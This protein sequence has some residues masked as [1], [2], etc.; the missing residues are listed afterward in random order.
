MHAEIKRGLALSLLFQKGQ[1]IFGDYIRQIS[2][3]IRQPAVPDH[4]GVMITAAPG[5]MDEP[6]RQTLLGFE[7]VAKMPFTGN[8]AMITVL[9][10]DIGV[11]HLAGQVFD[12][13]FSHISPGDPVVHAVLGRDPPG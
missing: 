13:P 8:S 7:A 2:R 4:R 6:V 10:K 1:P 3:L 5:L 11:R 9:G 12:G